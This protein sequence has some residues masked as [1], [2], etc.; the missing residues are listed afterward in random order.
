MTDAPG[1]SAARLLGLPGSLRKSSN[2]LAVLLGLHSV[3]PDTAALE[4]RRLDL[5]LYNQD[6][7][8]RASPPAVVALRQ[9]VAAS[10]GLV[11]VTPEYNYG[12]PGVLKNALDW[13]SRP[14]GKSAMVGKPALVISV[15]PAITGGVRAQGQLHMTLLGMSA[16]IVPGPQVVIGSARDKIRDGVLVDEATLAFTRAAVERLLAEIR[17]LASAA[18]V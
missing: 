7:D 3:L 18:Q 2:S 12:M 6:E 9:A 17:M 10:E 5:A 16:R 14:Y 4:I 8:G 1:F 15:S 11:I 13:L